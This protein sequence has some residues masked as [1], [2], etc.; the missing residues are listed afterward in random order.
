MVTR[1]SRLVVCD[2]S[3]VKAVK[4]IGFLKSIF[5][6]SVGLN[7]VVRVC[8]KKFDRRKFFVQHAI[9]KKGKSAVMARV[10]SKEM[11]KYDKKKKKNII[12][13]E[14][15]LYLAVIISSSKKWRR[16]DGVFLRTHRNR[17]I[18]LDNTYKLRSTRIRGPVNKELRLKR[19]SVAFAKNIYSN[20]GRK[21]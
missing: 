19:R 7:E 4:C 14:V 21:I 6:R 15:L 12:E 17:V 9:S 11:S 16:R 2:Q 5:T 3:G 18:F 20:A 1:S 10:V 13:A 8:I